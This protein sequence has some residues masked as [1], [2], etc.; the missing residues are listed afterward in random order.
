MLTRH[1]EQREAIQRRDA[2]P[3]CFVAALLAMT[4][5]VCLFSPALAQDDSYPAHS[6]R[7]IVSSLPGGNPDVLGRLLA[8]RMSNDFGKSFIVENVTGAGGALSAVAAAKASPDGYTLYLGDT[9]IMAINPLLNT[10][11]GY[12]PMKDFTPITGLV[13]LPTILVANPNKVQASTLS[14]FI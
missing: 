5:L 10:D 3:D 11:V 14:E 8:D 9:G 12:D 13:G 2:V 7:L 6:V 1:C 4:T